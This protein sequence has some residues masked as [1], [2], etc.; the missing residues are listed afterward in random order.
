M[1]VVVNFRELEEESG[2]KAGH[3]EEIGRLDF[4]FVGEPQLLEVHV[5]TGTEYTGTPVETRGKLWIERG[6]WG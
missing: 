6:R 4:E 3:L 5:F 2:L 1:T